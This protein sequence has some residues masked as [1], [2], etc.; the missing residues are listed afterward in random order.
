M[1]KDLQQLY[2]Q[3]VE[4]DLAAIHT[5]RELLLKIMEKLLDKGVL[6]IN[7]FVRED[8]YSLERLQKIAVKQV[9]LR[10]LIDKICSDE[11]IED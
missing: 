4:N 11:N 10:A 8:L 6:T 7:D 3:L 2:L 9:E 1:N 5:C